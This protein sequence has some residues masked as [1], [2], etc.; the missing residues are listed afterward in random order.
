MSAVLQSL[1][2]KGLTQ[3]KLAREADLNRGVLNQ[4]WQ[5][6]TSSTPLLIGRLCA[7]LDRNDAAELLAA[8]LE[9]VADDVWVQQQT[10]FGKTD[11]SG[12]LA[13]RPVKISVTYPPG[14]MAV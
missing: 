2:A 14:N 10:L 4:L 12:G 5:S 1:G 9:D 11:P 6:R 13:K 3:A 7:V 8:Y